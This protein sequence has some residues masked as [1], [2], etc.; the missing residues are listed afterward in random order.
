M[1]FTLEPSQGRLVKSIYGVNMRIGKG[2]SGSSSGSSINSYQG[3][4][5]T[6]VKTSNQSFDAVSSATVITYDSTAQFEVLNASDNISYNAGLFT[7]AAGSGVWEVDFEFQVASLTS[8]ANIRFA[9]SSAISS[10]TSNYL[11]PT[12]YKS[13][14]GTSYD[15]PNNLK[16]TL[17]CTTNAATICALVVSMSEDVLI[18]TGNSDLTTGIINNVKFKCL[19]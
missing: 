4:S 12:L 10:D 15:T 9:T 17:D 7:I 16:V 6:Y 14:Y 19:R 8:S 11:S 1:Q 5:V 13:G 18:L 2:N 3:A